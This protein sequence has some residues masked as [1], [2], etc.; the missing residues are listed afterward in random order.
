MR[1][2][3]L[4]MSSLDAR[5]RNTCKS[6]RSDAQGIHVPRWA[7]PGLLI[8][9][10]ARAGAHVCSLYKT[11]SFTGGPGGRYRAKGLQRPKGVDCIIARCQDST[12]RNEPL[13]RTGGATFLTRWRRQDPAET[14]TA[15]CPLRGSSSRLLTDARQR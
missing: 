7:R 4:N 5:S 10:T 3:K 1:A 11:Q 15:T 2:R 6:G 9:V 13:P 14:G 12:E 8:A